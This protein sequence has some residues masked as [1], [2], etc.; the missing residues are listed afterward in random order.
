V[1]ALLARGVREVTLL[2]QTVNAWSEDGEGFGTLLRRVGETGMER[3]RFTSPH[4]LFFS[5]E[6]LAAL[7][8]V[9]A[10][11][12]SVHLPMQS[13]NT[14]ILEMMNRGYTRE[15]YLEIAG[16][17]REEI[18]G[19]TLGTDVIVGFP[20]ES[21]AA[22][23]DTLS[24]MEI[25]AFD[26]SYQFKY[27]PR[28][29]TRAARRFEDDVPAGLK[30]ERLERVIEL[31]RELAAGTHAALLGRTLEVLI[32]GRGTRGEEQWTG[33]T[34][35]GHTVV[36]NSSEALLGRMIEV[37][38]VEAGVWTLRGRRTERETW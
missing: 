3:I 34:R 18:P 36:I 17:L 27:S 9:E 25:C 13:G 24:A 12:E 23:A 28:P 2:G 11:C 21:E 19:L 8:E 31:Q 33:R 6:E 35:G 38:I 26:S 32:E 14:A 37:E 1:E 16:R 22:F 30:Q 4:P 15:R 5:P 10:V 20:G 29:G 7:A